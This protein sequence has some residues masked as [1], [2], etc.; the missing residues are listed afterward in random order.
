MKPERFE[1]IVNRSQ[2]ICREILLE[3]NEEYSRDN[4]RLHNFYTAAR[5]DNTTPEVAL[6][7][8][9]KKH[10]V[11]IMDMI[12]DTKRGLCPTPEMVT[13]KFGDMHNY[14]Y[15]LEGLFDD[16]RRGMTNS[17]AVEKAVKQSAGCDNPFPLGK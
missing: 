9:A 7:G 11:S 1:T 16:R 14:L 8:M 10:L 6:W 5:V 17:D 15:L 4:E 12:E 2:T 3:K 13:E